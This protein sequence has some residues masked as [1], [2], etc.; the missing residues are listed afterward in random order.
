MSATAN[1]PLPSPAYLANCRWI[2]ARH[3]ELLRRHGPGWIAAH[4]GRVLAA[5]PALGPVTDAAERAAP[6]DE[7]GYYFLDDATMIY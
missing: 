3:T 5:G 2:M 4:G 1:I 6:P 7:I